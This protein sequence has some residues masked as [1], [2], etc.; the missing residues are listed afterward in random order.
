MHQPA[1]AEDLGGS[2]SVT[3]GKDGRMAAADAALR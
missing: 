2:E 1:T 3:A